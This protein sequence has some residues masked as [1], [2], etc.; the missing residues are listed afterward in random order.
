MYL[1]ALVVVAMSAWGMTHMQT[2]GNIVDDLPKEDRVL[3]DLGWLEDRFKGVMPFEVLVDGQK[4][5]QILS[6]GN[7]RRIEKFQNLLQEYPQFSRSL[8]A[9]DAVKFGVQAF[10]GGDPDRYRLPN[11][12]ERSF[13]GRTSAAA[14]RP[15]PTSTTPRR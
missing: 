15:P 10:Y 7:L 5:G 6:A 11:R 8:S 14:N 13:M 12:Q 1:A 9:V 3:T 4:P 2:T